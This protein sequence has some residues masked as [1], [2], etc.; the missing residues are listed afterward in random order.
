[1]LSEDGAVRAAAFLV[2]LAAMVA[3]FVIS[4]PARRA[5]GERLP[6]VAWLGRRI[7]ALR[8]RTI[9]LVFAACVAALVLAEVFEDAVAPG[10]R[11][12][13]HLADA[14][15]PD[16]RDSRSPLLVAAELGDEWPSEDQRY[17][18]VGVLLRYEHDIVALVPDGE[19]GTRIERY[20]DSEGYR[21]FYAYVGDFWGDRYLERD[22]V[23]RSALAVPSEADLGA[24]ARRLRRAGRV[25]RLCYGWDIEVRSGAREGRLA[26]PD[27]PADCAYVKLIAWV[28]PN[29][30]RLVSKGSAGDWGIN[31]EWTTGGEIRQE[32]IEA[33]DAP[34][35]EMIEGAMQKPSGRGRRAGK[36]LLEYLDV[37][38]LVALDV[39]DVEPVPVG[40]PFG[41]PHDA[42][43]SPVQR[44]D[45]ER[46]ADDSWIAYPP[47]LVRVAAI[48]TLAFLIFGLIVA[49]I[50]RGVRAIA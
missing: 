1:M 41:V 25:Q 23:P 31:Y 21:R 47:A 36:G 15:G 38:P 43:P 17:A 16:Y 40:T 46:R 2:A 6:P 48:F 28:D 33:I 22:D 45:A 24:V 7:M 35:V 42:R 37:M 20:D 32:S 8:W 19:G 34:L 18:G 9:G 30:G 12:A 3:V 26:G 13:D 29:A 50:A 10:G 11:L 39:P 49:G 4:R 27:I 14:F 44:T 5:V